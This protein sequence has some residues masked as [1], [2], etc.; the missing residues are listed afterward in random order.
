M[1][2]TVTVLY[3]TPDLEF[4]MEYYL[5]TH[6]P[7]VFSKWLSYGMKEWKVVKFEDSP[8]GTKPYSVA[9]VMTWESMDA[10]KTAL[11]GKEVEVI[12]G[13]VPNFSNKYALFLNGEV[14]GES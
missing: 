10:L 11:K 9:A 5:S 3:P 6:M 4:N 13:D 14:V 8:D 12:F 2:A 1:V 7:L